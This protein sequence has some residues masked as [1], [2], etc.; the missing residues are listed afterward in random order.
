MPAAIPVVAGE[1][2]L[3]AEV[4]AA[5]AAAAA[6]TE[7]ATA[8][9]LAEAAAAAEALQV[10]QA[11]ETAAA[12][13]EAATAATA[14]GTQAATGIEALTL[15]NPL[16]GQL[17]AD[18]IA[19]MIDPATGL[20]NNAQTLGQVAQAGPGGLD[21]L[22]Q[23]QAAQAGTGASS[24]TGSAA[25][26]FTG[27]P[28][29]VAP[30]PVAD[31]AYQFASAPAASPPSPAAPTP[32]SGTYQTAGA[33]APSTGP[34]FMSPQTIS[35]AGT[36]PVAEPGFFDKALD[37]IKNNKLSSASM[38]LN[39]LNMLNKKGP[40]E[41]EKYSGPLSK[42]K[43]DP[44]AYQPYEPEP[45]T[46]Y[47]PRMYYAGGGPVEMMSNANAIGAN[48]GYPMAD[49]NK[50]AY[51]TPYQ[52]PISR[53]VLTGTSDTGINPM[54]GEMQFAGG[55]ISSLGGYSDYARGGRMLKGPGDGMSDNIPATIAGKQPARLANEEFV[56]PADVVSHLGNGSSEAG[57]KALYK[58]MDRVRQART[59][60]KS[61]G[62]QIN[63]EKYL[64]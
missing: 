44:D 2:V 56:V 39:A 41:K 52:Q 10:A 37:Y 36:T 50:G 60:K 21:A 43:Y 23:A 22:S 51:A 54:T 13:T 14:A 5:E 34:N 49:I 63:P 58:M 35:T 7:A 42:F 11:A 25:S 24:Y 19:K 8:T 46:P 31:G 20:V 47:E 61:Q 38:G 55:G 28:P 33:P 29:S 48:T 3:A 1:A 45:P 53:N 18:Q 12:A 17:T 16:P 40:K 27:T 6:A 9:A 15:N 57:A 30:T 59:G 32:L 62:K 26:S 64:A 4:L